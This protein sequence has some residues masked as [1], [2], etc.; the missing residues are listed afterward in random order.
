MRRVLIALCAALALGGCGS[1]KTQRANDYVN[2]VN[3]AQNEF[4]ATFNKL[5]GQITAKSTAR[6][7]RS[8]L[9]K[10]EQAIDRVVAQLRAVRAP[11]NVRALHAQLITAIASYRDAVEKARRAF[12]T[13]D[14]D[15]LVRAQQSL[16]RSVT[17][18]SERITRT[19]N[20]INAKLHG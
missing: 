19:I 17:R 14:R 11:Q 18:I 12:A 6:Q 8:T 7:D 5:E 3:R 10:F 16:V 15:K 13:K 1:Q 9:K 4:A 2:A 20:E